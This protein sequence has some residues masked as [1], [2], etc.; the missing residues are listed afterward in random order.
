L[1]LRTEGTIS[2]R[3]HARKHRAVL[4]HLFWIVNNSSSCSP[5]HGVCGRCAIMVLTLLGLRFFVVCFIYCEDWYLAVQ[6]YGGV[7]EVSDF[8]WGS[9]LLQLY[10]FSAAFL[11][12]SR[13]KARISC[14]WSRLSTSSVLFPALRRGL[15]PGG[16]RILLCWLYRPG[17]FSP[18]F[19]S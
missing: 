1:R 17:L 8:D 2:L 16:V 3:A 5:P 12:A 9:F 7:E 11:A 6:A 15:R 13:V 19:E 18:V 14:W 4:P 10:P